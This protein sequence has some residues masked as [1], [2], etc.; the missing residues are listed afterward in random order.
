M[1]SPS[2]QLI[3]QIDITNTCFNKCSNCT[4][5][6][7]HHKKPFSMDFL[8]FQKACESLYLYKGMVGLIGGE[9]TLH[10][11]FERFVNF[12]ADVFP[13]M[14]PEEKTNPPIEEGN[15]VAYRNKNWNIT[16][17]RKRGLWTSLGPGYYRHYE[18]IRKVFEYQCINDHKNAGKHRAL[19]ITRKELGIPDE[20]FY[21]LRDACWVQN[22]WSATI[23]PK[24]AFF[25]EV[26]GALDMLLD[27]PGGWPVTRDWWQRTPEDFKDQLHWCELCSAPLAVPVVESSAEIDIVS[28]QWETRLKEIGSRKKR[29]VFDVKSYDEKKYSVNHLY[30]PYLPDSDEKM[31]ADFDT[32]NCLT[33]KKINIVIVCVGYGKYLSKTLRYNAVE[34][35]NITIVTVLDDDET[36]D[37]AEK[38]AA[39]IVL[40]DRLYHNNAIFNKGALTNEGIVHALSLNC[41]NWILIMDADCILN[42]GAGAYI[43]KLVLNPGTLY[44]AQRFSI[45]ADKVEDSENLSRDFKRLNI[46]Y[47]ANNYPYGY[48]QLFRTDSSVF[49]CR[50]KNQ[51]YSEEYYSAGHVDNEFHRLWH[52]EKWFRLPDI[53]LAHLHHGPLSQNWQ[54]VK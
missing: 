29:E 13:R 45:D 5:F 52:P 11:E 49:R 4:R 22:L 48:F 54:G 33:V 8:T 16:A 36:I 47:G 18:I 41:G 25:C 42:Q 34:A 35:D 39:H 38:A 24:G 28:P 1:K 14:T 31:R 37:A 32:L 21:R 50:Q 10:P 20:K 7:G 12:Y 9:P 53:Q 44:Y 3:I 26:A 46:D 23:T 6:C 40:S 17:K 30:V 15:F 27:G 2:S 19:M 43:R 51:W